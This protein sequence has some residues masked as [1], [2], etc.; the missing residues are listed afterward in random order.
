MLTSPEAS[1]AAAAAEAC[2]EQLCAQGSAHG[3]A[4]PAAL[5]VRAASDLRDPRQVGA[6]QSLVTLVV[7]TAHAS[8]ADDTLLVGI[9]ALASAV[10]SV[11]AALDAQDPTQAAKLRRRLLPVLEGC[12]LS[13]SMLLVR[14]QNGEVD[15]GPQPQDGLIELALEVALHSPSLDV[16]SHA[17]SLLA[18][19]ARERGGARPLL[20]PL[21]YALHAHCMPTARPLHVQVCPASSDCGP[22]SAGLMGCARSSST[23]RQR[24]KASRWATSTATSGA[25]AAAARRSTMAVVSRVQAAARRC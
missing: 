17:S 7:Q 19:C 21:A 25:Q 1:I 2:F 10:L 23:R 4:L 18:A 6:A 9:A 16:A 22:A 20:V 14:E 15:G 5:K 13:A 24:A 11:D 8:P 12:L 3:F